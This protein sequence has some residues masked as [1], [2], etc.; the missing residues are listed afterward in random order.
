M[1]ITFP[2]PDN[3]EPPDLLESRWPG[4]WAWPE[5][6]AETADPPLAPQ[7]LGGLGADKPPVER[8]E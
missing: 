7:S 5:V 6:I 1:T 3:Y 2:A 8:G 4:W